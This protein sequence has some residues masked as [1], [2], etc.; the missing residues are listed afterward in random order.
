MI[1]NQLAPNR[2]IVISV[3]D[4][5]PDNIAL[6]RG[7][8]EL[9]LQATFFIELANDSRAQEQVRELHAMGITIGSH[10]LTHPSDMKALT[11][12]QLRGELQTS[13]AMI[14]RQTGVPCRTFCYPRGR[15]D[16]RVQAAVQAAGYED[17]RTT[18]VCKLSFDPKVQYAKPTTIHAYDG[19]KE[20]G[21]RK[22]IQVA[23]EQFQIFMQTGGVFHIW[24][25]ARE[26]R[27]DGISGQFL[28]FLKSITDG[29]AENGM[30]ITE[31]WV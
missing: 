9:G 16:A 3:D 12:E 25:H 2:H 7:I 19:R 31:S 1:S 10:S 17:A 6:A 22:W 30:A 14:E 4:Y 23:S 20:Y 21:G 15:H 18:V 28:G 11:D 26:M 27:R 24:G 5:D 29:L 13:K 8:R